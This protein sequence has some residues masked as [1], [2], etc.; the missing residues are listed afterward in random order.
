MKI[1]DEIKTVIVPVLT[2]FLRVCT[3]CGW[4]H[5]NIDQIQFKPHDM[6]I[7]RAPRSGWC[8]LVVVIIIE[9][10]F[11]IILYSI[12]ISTC[13]CTVRVSGTRVNYKITQCTCTPVKL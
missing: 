9:S 2:Y 6:L 11:Y 8:V 7:K 12:G 13:T 1:V 5:E 3:T 10:L 4:L